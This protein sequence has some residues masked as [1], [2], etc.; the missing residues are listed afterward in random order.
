MLKWPLRLMSRIGTIALI[1]YLLWIGWQHL[2]P[3]KPDVSPMRMQIANELV[4]EIVSDLREARNGIRTA[5]LLHLENDPSEYVTQSLRHAVETSGIIT[6]RNPTLA[7]RVRDALR[8]PQHEYSDFDSALRRA[9]SLGVQAVIFGTVD[10]FESTKDGA[11][12]DLRL[13]F[14][15]VE[16]ERMLFQK[17]Y[18]RDRRAGLLNHAALQERTA[19]IPVV[20][21]FLGW[22]AV[23]LL[24]PVFTIGFIRAMVRKESNQANALV[25]GIYTAVAAILAFFL[26]GAT[27]VT[28]F[29]AL[30]L[31][32]ATAIA[33]A[34][35]ASIMKYA[36]RLES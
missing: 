9:S 2:G 1:A 8:L 26:M 33:L 5:A 11:R 35:N 19:G 23:V 30:V 16:S 34:Y 32:T 12:L 7:E 13:Y 17:N 3:R 20:Q 14:V 29:A 25:L 36:V 31:L 21:R 22:L 10:V 6:L 24:L 28:W 15:D 27:I 4:P 18:S